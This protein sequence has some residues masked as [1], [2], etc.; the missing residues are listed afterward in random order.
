MT[1]NRDEQNLFEQAAELAIDEAYRTVAVVR[2]MT[3][4]V[5]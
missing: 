2:G 5:A 1:P 3:L 4:V